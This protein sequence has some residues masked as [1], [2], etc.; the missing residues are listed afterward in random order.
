MGSPFIFYVYV[1]RQQNP[2]QTSPYFDFTKVVFDIEYYAKIIKLFVIL[3]SFFFQRQV[4]INIPV[5]HPGARVSKMALLLKKLN[6]APGCET[7]KQKTP[8]IS[9]GF[10]SFI[11]F[12]VKKVIFFHFGKKKF[13][14]FGKE[15][16]FQL[17]DRYPF[18]LYC[19]CKC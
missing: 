10:W 18:F 6:F 2:V 3:F 9:R 8:K 4:G 15:F 7:N 19:R 1:H 12:N 11:V 14:D 16:C 5:Q 17:F 13:L